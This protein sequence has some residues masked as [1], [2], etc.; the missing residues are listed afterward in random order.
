LQGGADW[1]MDMHH[2]YQGYE[3]L[4]RLIVNRLLPRHTTGFGWL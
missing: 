4:E 3:A 2:G 1:F